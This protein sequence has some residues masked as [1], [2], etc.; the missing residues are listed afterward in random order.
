MTSGKKDNYY[1]VNS[2]IKVFKIIE[3]LSEQPEYDLTELSRVAGMP[4]PTVQRMLLTLQQLG[5]IRQNPTNSR[6]ALTS[7]LFE[8]GWRIMR[9]K[10]H[11]SV[12]VE[13]MEL[14]AAR[15]IRRLMV[16]FSSICSPGVST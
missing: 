12:A 6:Y 8:V 7:R 3:A 14:L 11:V 16:R 4:K 13:E 9:K 2:V 1:Q 10:N 15:F 5:Y